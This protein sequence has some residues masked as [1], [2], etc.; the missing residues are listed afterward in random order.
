MR[1]PRLL[2]AQTV[3]WFA[4]VAAVCAVSAG[5]T[6]HVASDGVAQALPVV[7]ALKDVAISTSVR[8]TLA[9]DPYLAGTTIDVATTAGIVTL[10]GRVSD[11]A[12]RE[13]AARLARAVFGVAR[14]DNRLVATL[15]LG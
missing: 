13:Y 2:F 8:Q 15:A 6:P 5:P 3:F 10:Q 14:V 7:D 4:V 9:A 1:T 11:L 12:L